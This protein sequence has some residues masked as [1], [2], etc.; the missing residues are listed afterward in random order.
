V[1]VQTAFEYHQDLPTLIGHS[2]NVKRITHVRRILIGESDE[3]PRKSDFANKFGP[4][5]AVENKAKAAI[6]HWA[7][8]LSPRKDLVH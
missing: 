5:P 8:R 3:K 6:E 1:E 4:D 7:G 2:K